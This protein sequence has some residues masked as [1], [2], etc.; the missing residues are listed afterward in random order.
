MSLD[1]TAIPRNVLDRLLEVERRLDDLEGFAALPVADP[2]GGDTTYV[3][4][5]Q[6][7]EIGEGPGIDITGTSPNQT[8]GI[9]GDTILLYDSGGSPVA[10]FAA[11]DAGLDL[12]SAAATAG[13]V[14]WL[15][16]ATITGDHALTAGV[17]YIG[18]SRYASILTGQITMGAGTTLEC[19]TV[20]RTAND[21]N[22]LV[23]V[24]GPA[25]EVAMLR[26]CDVSCVQSGSGAAYAVSVEGGGDLECWTCALYGEST[27]GIG[28]GG[29]RSGGGNLYIYG[30]RCEGSSYPLSE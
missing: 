1:R 18:V 12:A 5:V 29:S 30:G 16:A 9:G 8:V 21:A 22:A 2:E 19:V 23:G 17:H 28:Y 27:G 14:V 4:I 11:T 25:S 20:S 24:L 3:S 10:E 6:E 7:V 13:D 26:D 15:P